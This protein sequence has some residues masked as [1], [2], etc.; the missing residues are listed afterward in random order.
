MKDAHDPD[1]NARNALQANDQDMNIFIESVI[2][3]ALQNNVHTELIGEVGI[4]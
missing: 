4:I 3:G 1:K 2:N